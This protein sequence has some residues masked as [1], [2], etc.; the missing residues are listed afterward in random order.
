MMMDRFPAQ[1]RMVLMTLLKRTRRL[2]WV[3][4]KFARR[5]FAILDKL[6]GVIQLNQ[7]VHKDREDLQ[8]ARIT[9]ELIGRRNYKQISEFRA[10]FDIRNPTLNPK[11]GVAWLHKEI[12]A[13]SSI[14]HPTELKKFEPRPLFPEN[15]NEAVVV[16]PDNGY[17]HFLTEELPRYLEVTAHFPNLL[18]AYSSSS[19]KYVSE[20]LQ[21]CEVR[22]KAFDT[23]I[24][25]QKLL[26]SEKIKGGL[27]TASDLA[28]LK[29]FRERFPVSDFIES[30]I[31]IYR[32]DP[33]GSSRYTQRGLEKQKVFMDR[34]ISE[35]F[36]IVKLEDMSFRDQ[37]RMFSQAGH[38]A[39]FHGAG[40]ANQIWMPPGGKVTEYVGTRRTQHFRHLARL[41]G[42]DYTEES[43]S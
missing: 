33:A 4:Q 3:C 39:G 13:E 28:I 11:T 40:L 1:H 21:A 38:V 5:F 32:S 22:A 7:A 35:G 6:D 24:R 31:F 42:H 14:W 2:C 12:I 43:I 26:L 16:L 23:P 41:A 36:Q 8:V 19:S 25:V 15:V 29:N 30:K 18:S 27:M 37:I 20:V 17:F 9:E 34:L 10:I